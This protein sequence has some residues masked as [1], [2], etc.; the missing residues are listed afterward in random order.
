M[1]A[2]ACCSPISFTCAARRSR[3]ATRRGSASLATRATLR[4][5]LRWRSLGV[6]GPLFLIGGR[7]NE[8]LVSVYVIA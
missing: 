8:S 6:I 2:S 7:P 3:F 4:R 1:L 5:H